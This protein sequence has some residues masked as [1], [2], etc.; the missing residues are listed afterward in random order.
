MSRA[1][2]HWEPLFSDDSIDRVTAPRSYPLKLRQAEVDGVLAMTRARDK[3]RRRGSC[4]TKCCKRGGTRHQSEKSVCITRSR[5][6]LG[7][8]EGTKLRYDFR[9]SCSWGGTDRMN[10]NTLVRFSWCT[11][12]EISKPFRWKIIWLCL[13]RIVS[14]CSMSSDRTCRIK[15][16][17][18]CSNASTSN[19]AQDCA[20][21]LVRISWLLIPISSS[22]MHPNLKLTLQF[23]TISSFCILCNDI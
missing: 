21:E 5:W 11:T 17:Y 1:H 16:W 20:G 6:G 12:L 7:G 4:S 18:L 13:N 9:D 8:V 14:I 22:N 15:T 10:N 3:T 2:I 19:I 23:D